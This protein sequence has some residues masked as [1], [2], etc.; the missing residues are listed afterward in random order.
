MEKRVV[1]RDLGCLPIEILLDLTNSRI[2]V[3]F[4]VASDVVR[5][6]LGKDYF[7]TGDLRDR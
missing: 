1:G 7:L 4:D 2:E 6:V 5:D 3:D